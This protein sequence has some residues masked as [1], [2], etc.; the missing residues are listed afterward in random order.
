MKP[1][2]VLAFLAYAMWGLFPLYFSQLRSVPA[3]EVLMHRVAWSG[4]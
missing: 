2:I 4:V 3:F 1:G